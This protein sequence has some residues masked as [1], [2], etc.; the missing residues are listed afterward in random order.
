MTSN[1]F[2]TL[3]DRFGSVLDDFLGSAPL[4]R[5]ASADVTVEE[6]RSYIKQVYYYVRENPQI[7]AVGTAYFRGQQRSTVRSVLAHAVSEV[8]H[9]QMALDDYVA[10]GGDASVVPYRN[11]HPATT[12]LTSFAYYQI[13]N[14]N[15]VGY[16]GYLFFLEFS[17]T[18]V[19]TKLCEQLLACNVPEHAL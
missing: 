12:A 2:A 9:E 14:L 17:P 7:Q 5:L 1:A 13:H 19:G 10:L 6:Y 18:Q 11:P 16:L 3:A 8:G 4:R 15:P